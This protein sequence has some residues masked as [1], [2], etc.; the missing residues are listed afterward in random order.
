MQ[1]SLKKQ[2][3]QHEMRMAKHKCTLYKQYLDM[4][5][6][7]KR[8]AIAPRT[9]TAAFLL[10]FAWV[11]VHDRPKRPIGWMLNTIKQA[12]IWASVTKLLKKIISS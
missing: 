12:S 8:L 6:V 9:I 5:S 11:L 7:T 3:Q 2:I 10:G 4:L 1:R